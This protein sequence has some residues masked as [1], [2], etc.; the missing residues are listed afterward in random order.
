MHFGCLPTDKTPWAGPCPAHPLGLTCLVRVKKRRAQDTQD[1]V[2]WGT[3]CGVK[4]AF[5]EEELETQQWEQAGLDGIGRK[6]GSREQ[7]SGTIPVPH[8]SQPS[9]SVPHSCSSPVCCPAK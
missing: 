1:F 7:R 4:A 6:A 5:P 8:S 9:F 2:R 3:G